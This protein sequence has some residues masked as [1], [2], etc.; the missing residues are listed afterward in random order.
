MASGE[1]DNI[2]LVQLSPIAR[3]V[4]KEIAHDLA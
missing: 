4:A 1:S 3:K 2:L